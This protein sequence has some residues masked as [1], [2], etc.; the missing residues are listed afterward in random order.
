MK[1]NDVIQAI[2]SRLSLADMA[3]RYVELRQAGSRLMAPCPFHQETKPSFS[4]NEEQGTFYCFGCQASGD[5]FDFYGRLNGLDF[6]E[7]LAALAEEA[8][9]QIDSYRQAPGARQERSKKRDMLK[10][11]E[12]AAAHFRSNL[13]SKGAAVC[14]DYVAE[15]GISPEIQEKFGL[16]WSTDSW[17]DLAGTLLRAGFSQEA[18]VECGLLSKSQSSR[19]FDRFR[20]R[21]MF[22]IRSLSGQ[23]IAFG[24]RVIP[25]LAG[26]NDAKYINSSDSPIYKKGEHLFGLFQARPS[27]AVKK[28]ILLT[29]G[30]MDV[31]TLHQY[32]YTQAVGVLGTALTPEQIKRLSGFS[33]HLELM[34]DGDNAGHK[35]AFRSCEMLLS[36]GLSCKVILFPDGNDIDSMLRSYG[37]DAVEDLRAH[38]QDGLSFCLSALRSMTPREAVEWVRRFLSQVEMPELFNRFAQELA[39]G[40]GLSEAEL[41]GGVLNKKKAQSFYV[42]K[43]AAPRNI[44]RDREIMIFAVRYPHRLPDLQAIG[45]DLELEE[46]WTIKLW[47]KLARY[48]SKQVFDALDPK[49]K[50]F[51]I[52][53]RGEDAPPLNNEEG[54]FLAIKQMMRTLQRTTHMASVVA[55]ISQGTASRETQREYMRALREAR[56]RHSEQ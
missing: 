19:I 44:R 56:G 52:R 22:P 15:R 46:P 18:A 51:W 2:K 16:G 13:S 23:A 6:K 28:N 9:I 36:R 55:A 1:D 17:Q 10:M 25:S 47:E 35:A 53:C 31:I 30:Y 50:N 12:L 34:F 8:G 5:I 29:E 43:T 3:R 32:G 20:N 49:E 33:P 4:I 7:T 39:T 48:D 37:S 21:L 54:E 26:E 14:R 38:A 45:A 41:R 42:K 40:L 11:H 27:I 24:G